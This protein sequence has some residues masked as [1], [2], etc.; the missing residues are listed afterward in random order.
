[1]A[2]KFSDSN[3][4]S[5]P[6]CA[7][8]FIKLVIKNMR[9]RKKVQA[10]VLAELAAHFE[11]GLRDCQTDEEKEQK[12]QK[13]IEDFGDSKL[14]GV[15]LRRAKKRCRPLW[16]TVIV[17]TFQT[18]GVLILCLIFYCF[19]ISLG[20]PNIT[21]N[22]VQQANLLV[23]PVADESLNA[24]PLYQKA[25]AAYKEPPKIELKE[26]HCIEQ[27]SIEE[28]SALKQW[29]SDNND[30]IR[31]FRQAGERP[32]CWWQR[33][34][35]NDIVI[36]VIM[37][38]LSSVK[39]MAT[40]IA[41]HAKLKAQDGNIEEA[42]DDLLACYRAGM[43]LKGPRSLVEQLVGMAIQALSVWGV[44]DILDNQ[45]IDGQLLKSLL[46]KFQDLVGRDSFVASYDVERFCGLDFLQRCYTDNGRGS[47]HMIPGRAKE[48]FHL[49]REYNTESEF[50]EFGRFLVMS[51]ASTDREQMNRE[52]DKMYNIGQEW[53][54][55]T[56]WQLRQ[57][58]ADLGM[59]MENWSFFRKARLWPIQI[60]VPVV[61]QVSEIAHRA[62]A[63]CE[64]LITVMSI[65][66][67]KQIHGVY[68]ENLNK[69]LETDL[70]TKLPMDPFSDKP[71]V[72]RKTDDGFTLYSVGRNF[73]D[74]GGKPSLDRKG[75]PKSWA[76]DGDAVFWPVQK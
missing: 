65:L 4:Q 49:M 22:Y 35:K 70:L 19:Y 68:P 23:R 67:Y 24:A 64:A 27:L 33:Q 2:K 46:D 37:P 16:R 10:D 74:D 69:L 6:A 34:T 40:V 28:F 30:A 7:T 26:K 51:L 58:N 44:F 60:F 11:D 76:D 15:L 75:K 48:C 47:G 53:A 31:F 5:L 3:L 13:L 63:Y 1:M 50:G 32:Y 61:A 52:F 43:H 59:G 20:R 57:E 9:Y 18:T 66:R 71:L 42:L 21:I 54:Y 38:E 72:Y 17:R 14:L 62:K 56:P 39:K 12:A 45:K 36:N 73:T 8:E 29:L 25:F 41:W 55:K